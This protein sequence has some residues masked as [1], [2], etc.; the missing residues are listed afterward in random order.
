[1]EWKGNNNELMEV[2]NNKVNNKIERGDWATEAINKQSINK[3][4]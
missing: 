4:Q 2:A 1:M 3:Q